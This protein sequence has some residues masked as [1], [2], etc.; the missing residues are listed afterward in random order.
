MNYA[1]RIEPA[2]SAYAVRGACSIQSSRQPLIDAAKALRSAGAADSDII[3]VSGSVISISP[4]S[5][6]AVLKHRSL[7]QAKYAGAHSTSFN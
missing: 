6:G 2:G 7:P 1:I 5:I 4:V 3:V